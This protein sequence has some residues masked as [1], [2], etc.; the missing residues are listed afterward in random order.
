YPVPDKCPDEI[1]HL[2]EWLALEPIEG[3]CT[4]YLNHLMQVVCD[5]NEEA[6]QDL[7]QWMA[8]ISQKPDEKPS[9]A[10]VMKS[11]TGTGKGTTVIPLLQIPGQYA[12]HI[13]GAGHTSGPFNSI[14]AHKLLVFA[15]E[16]TLHNASE[17]YRPNA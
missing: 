10:I 7:I 8:N 11:V 2:Y 3:D 5:G 14:L 9:V 6:C 12:A 17:A 13:N 16:V 1:F 15:D 4:L